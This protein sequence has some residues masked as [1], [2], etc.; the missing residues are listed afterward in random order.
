MKRLLFS[1][2][3]ILCVLLSTKSYAQQQW[4]GSLNL[5][6]PIYRM[7]NV[8]IGVENP[9]SRLDVLK[10]IQVSEAEGA[11]T[12]F[13]AGDIGFI[14]HRGTGNGRLIF[15]VGNNGSDFTNSK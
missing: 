6:Q 8:G 14:R 12:S 9:Q 5:N 2:Q 10:R 11:F 3:L 1:F 15:A 13:Q 7:G 4:E